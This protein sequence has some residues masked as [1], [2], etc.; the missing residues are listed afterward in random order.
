MSKIIIIRLKTASVTVGP[1]NISDDRGNV[2]GTNVSRDALISGVT[3]V[4][5]DSVNVVVVES[6]GKCKKKQ[7]FPITTITPSE[8]AISMEWLNLT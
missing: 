3:Y 2:L 6:T 1:F 8:Q 7:N 4:V 5:D